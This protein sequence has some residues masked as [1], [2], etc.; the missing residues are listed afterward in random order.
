MKKRTYIIEENAVYY[1]KASSAHAAEQQLLDAISL[2]GAPIDCEVRDRDVS[3][4][5]EN[6]TVNRRV[7]TRREFQIRIEG[8]AE[9]GDGTVLKVCKNY[10]TEAA[11]KKAW[12]KV[13][14]A[15][16][17]DMNAED[18]AYEAELIEVLKLETL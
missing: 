11:A 12:P 6:R 5:P 3:P 13:L 18:D 9:I 10:Q 4:D 15:F 2:S 17:R 14:K 1:V 8:Y 7:A 16:K